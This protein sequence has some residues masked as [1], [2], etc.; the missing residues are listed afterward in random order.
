[1]GLKPSGDL[2]LTSSLCV[3]KKPHSSFLPSYLSS[4][5]TSSSLNLSSLLRCSPYRLCGISIYAF[6]RLKRMEKRKNGTFFVLPPLALLRFPG[7]LHTYCMAAVHHAEGLPMCAEKWQLQRECEMESDWGDFWVLPVEDMVLSVAV[8]MRTLCMLS[9]VQI[10]S[11]HTH[12]P[13]SLIE[14][15]VA[16]FKGWY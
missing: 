16:R 15:D 5:I 4:S 10:H 12:T 7:G 3:M 6:S 13:A 11:I 2:E 1:M 9:R 8:A 14:P